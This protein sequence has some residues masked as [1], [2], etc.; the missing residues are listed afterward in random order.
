MITGDR[1][2]P[3]S[4]LEA[5]SDEEVVRRVR[6]G[7]TALFGIVMRRYNQRLYR[8]TRALVRDDAEAEDVLQQAYVNA[9]THL[10][11]FAGEARFAT[12]LTR[13]AT[14]EAFARLRRRGRRQ[15]KSAAGGVEDAM[16]ALPTPLPDPERQAF[17]GEL[18]RALEA[19]LDALPANY[20][21]VF[22]LRDVEGLSTVEA[23]ECLGVSEDV[24][25]TRL[26]RAR[27]LLR[28]DLFERAGLSARSVFSFAG[29]R[30]D[31]IVAAVLARLGVPVVH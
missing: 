16:D 10:H 28:E 17:A 11:Q 21:A 15:E 6:R 26:S 23:A 27:A 24:V 5:L 14:Y 18:R 22:V 12:W 30:C 1:P 9:Y 25:K 7:E 2:A 3:A 8:V 4:A 29:D 13:I 20:R 31:R 19:S